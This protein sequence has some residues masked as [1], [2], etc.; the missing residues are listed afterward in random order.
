MLFIRLF[1]F[2]H[3]RNAAVNCSGSSANS[4]RPM[5][6]FTLRTILP[7]EKK[8]F[9]SLKS[10]VRKRWQINISKPSATR[11]L[12]CDNSE[13]QF[14]KL[15]EQGGGAELLSLYTA[16]MSFVSSLQLTVY[17]V[18]ASFSLS[19]RLYALVSTGLGITLFTRCLSLQ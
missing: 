1:G 9:K 8:L 6:C 7:P 4:T 15:L 2:H 14:L 18:C 16:R 19:K 3:L 13:M 11:P 12:L 17:S 5:L 10:S